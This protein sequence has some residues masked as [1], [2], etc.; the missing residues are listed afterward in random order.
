MV[1]SYPI[2][3]SEKYSNL[4]L[5]FTKTI[6]MT[7]TEDISVPLLD[8]HQGTLF[9]WPAMFKPLEGACEPAD[10]GS[11]QLLHVPAGSSSM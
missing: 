5:E 10:V 1:S 2:V 6:D 3:S 11:G 7:L 9:A 4:K 8:L